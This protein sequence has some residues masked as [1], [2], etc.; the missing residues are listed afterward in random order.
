MENNLARAQADMRSAY[1]SGA[2][3][4][5]ASAIVWMCAAVAAIYGTSVTA[6]WTLLIGGAFIHPA[7]IVIS[8][9][10]GGS[11]DH[12]KNNPLASLA[13]ASTV[14]LL[15]SLIL[16]YAVS[17]LHIE[18]FFP[19]VLMII[20]GRYTVFHSLYGMKVFWVLGLALAAA[21]LLLALLR[22]H[23]VLSASVGALAEVGFGL[24]VFVMHRRMLQFTDDSFNGNVKK[25]DAS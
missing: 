3:G 1:I 6:V 9:I 19:A 10:L 7:A 21:G 13:G 22:A 11:G 17:L 4:I 18:W 2:A 8:K 16:A 25:S 5:L 12:S 15:L 23:P 20:A 24:T 14:W